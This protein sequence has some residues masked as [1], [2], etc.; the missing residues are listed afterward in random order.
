MSWARGMLTDGDVAVTPLE[1]FRPPE[2]LPGVLPTETKMAMDSDMSDIYRYANQSAGCNESFPGYPILAQ[3]TQQAEYRMLSEKTAMAMVRKW[4][5]LR[6]KGDDDKTKKLAEIE[7][8]M[9]RL[10]VREL[11]GEAAKLDGFFGRAQIFIDLGEQTGPALENPMFMDK[12]VLSNKLRKFKVIEA[13]Y[14]YPND[15]S[16]S[17][18]MADDYYAPRTWFVMGQKVHSTRLLTFVGRPLP[19]MLKPAYNFGGLSMSQL[20]RPTVENWKK[21]QTSVCKLI[22]NFSTSGIKTDMADVLAGG[23]GEGLLGRAQL[24][25]E[26]RDNQDLMLLDF[27]HEDFFQYNVPLTTIDKLQAQAQEQMA[28][29]SSMP[30]SILLGVTPTGLNASTDGEIRIF[31]DHVADMQRALFGDNLTKVIELIQLSKYGE[32]DP[33]ILYDFVPLWEQSDT[34]RAANRK[35]DAE[36]AAI[37]MEIGA[38]RPEEVRKK[39]ST[40]EDSGYNG[41]DM[42]VTVEPQQ[43]EPD[44]D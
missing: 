13:M 12:A 20:A 3:M 19:D 29:V 6:S 36:C 15:Y 21:T 16:A 23:D 10:K 31:Y 2:M 37:Y 39:L 44:E 8:E 43:D 33:D 18:P 1:R 7:D 35:S 38:I 41:L 32:V 9:K 30:L 25:T 24:Y 22:S 17:N 34:E 5:K 11:F 28:S 26:M 27:D 4:V 40:D 14:T 42:G